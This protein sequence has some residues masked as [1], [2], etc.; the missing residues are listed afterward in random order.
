MV[1]LTKADKLNPGPRKNVVQQV[2]KA[3]TVFGD[4]VHVEAFSSLK[5]IGV[6]PVIK[7]LSEWYQADYPEHVD[8]E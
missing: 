1:L 6:E 4:N 8:E 2:R 3:T 5:G 7:I